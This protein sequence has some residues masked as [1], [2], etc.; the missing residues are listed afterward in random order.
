APMSGDAITDPA[1]GQATTSRPSAGLLSVEAAR[2]AVLAVA[3]PLGTERVASA[4]ALG[5]IVAE[6][7][8]AR[9]SLPPWPN[10]AMDG[11]AIV[12]SDTATVGEDAPGHLVV[13]GDIRAGAAPDVT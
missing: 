10:S 2:D 4:D 8:V 5:R 1:A 11:Y 3:E 7:P 13:I 6:A 12:A 9:T